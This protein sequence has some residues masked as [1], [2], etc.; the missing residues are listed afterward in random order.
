[1]GSF[2]PK[3]NLLLYDTV[4][5]KWVE[6]TPEEE[7]RQRI[8]GLMLGELGYPRAL[9]SIERELKTLPHLR[10][11]SNKQIPKRRADIL[12]FSKQESSLLPLLLIECKA[13]SL[14]DKCV[15]QVLGY[16]RFVQAPWLCVANH[17]KILTGHFDPDQGTFR[18]Y[19]GLPS[20]QRLINHH[21]AAG[22]QAQFLGSGSA[23]TLSPSH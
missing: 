15:Q 17:R 10:G 2:S 6:R 5:E 21:Q 22:E 19:P 7:V 8:L 9:V 12:V 20:Y 13:V 1:M 11:R 16:N 4:R 18:F 23:H 3:D 14:T